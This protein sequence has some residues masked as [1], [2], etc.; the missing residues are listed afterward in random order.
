M[1]QFEKIGRN[2]LSQGGWSAGFLKRCLDWYESIYGP[3]YA[4]RH[5]RQSVMRGRSVIQG[6]SQIKQRWPDIQSHEEQAPVFILSAGWR[7]GSTLMQRLIMSKQSILVWGEPYSHARVIN[8]LA[9]VVSSITDSW[10]Q[11][12]WFIDQYDL[13]NLK[14][15]FVAN[16]YPPVSDMQQ[17]CLAYLK[18]MLEVPARERGFERWGLKDVRLTIEDAHFLKWLFPNAK[19][20]FLCR[21][22]YNAYKSYRLDRSWYFEWPNKP[23]FTAS[24]FGRN[25]NELAKGFY[26]GASDLGGIFIR[27]EDLVSGSIDHDALEKYLELEID[28]SLLGKKVGSHHKSGEDLPA[29]ELKQL[30]K[31]VQHMAN[32][33]DYRYI[34]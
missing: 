30:R 32:I 13:N 31:E 15:T 14:S 18:A 8:H 17:G 29:C 11:D 21:N 12:E 34:E 16:M 28:T 4:Q 26:E 25:W 7:S 5:H 1:K 3:I 24:E 33:L 22:P 27:Y 6:L 20:I 23:V 10:P 19:F 9:D 2:L